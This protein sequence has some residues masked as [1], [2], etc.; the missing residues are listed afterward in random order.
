MKYSSPITALVL[1][2]IIPLVLLGATSVTKLPTAYALEGK[3]QINVAEADNVAVQVN[4]CGNYGIVKEKSDVSC[5]NTDYQ[6][7]VVA[8]TQTQAADPNGDGG[9]N[10]QINVADTNNI[11]LQVN[12]CGNYGIVKEKSD[13]SCSNQVDQSNQV[14][15]TQAADPNGDG[16]SNT[17]LNYASASNTAYQANACG[18]YGLVKDDSA[19]SCSNQA[20][21][22]NLIGQFQQISHEDP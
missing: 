4:V 15:Q 6:K 12:V 9:S 19:V 11:A 5:S 14:A 2:A 8:Q 10:T 21:Q 7:N 22:S 13:V 18:N 17:Q 16:G 1:A 20:D 3:P